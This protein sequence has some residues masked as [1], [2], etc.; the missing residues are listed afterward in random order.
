VLSLLGQFDAALDRYQNARD[1]IT[2]VGEPYLWANLWWRY[3]L[4]MTHGNIGLSL[5]QQKKFQEAIDAFTTSATEVTKVVLRDPQQVEWR[6][7]FAWTQD[8]IG[9]TKIMWAWTEQNP[10]RLDGA[11]ADLDK[12]KVKRGELVQDAPG[13]SRYLAEKEITLANIEAL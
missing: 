4:A 13:V 3:A 11:D 6:E 8:V 5:R 10:A 2:R 12:A 9:E 7:W 1:G